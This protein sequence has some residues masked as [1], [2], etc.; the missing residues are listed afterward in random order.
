MMDV[1]P[2]HPERDDGGIVLLRKL[3]HGI[4]WLG[5]WQTKGIARDGPRQWPWWLDSDDQY[6]PQ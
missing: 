6:L 1:L 4:P 3:F 5:V 2:T